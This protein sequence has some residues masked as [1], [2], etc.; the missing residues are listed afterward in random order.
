MAPRVPRASRP[1]E[2]PKRADRQPSARRL[3][4]RAPSLRVHDRHAEG[5]LLGRAPS[6]A[7]GRWP[8][9]AGARRGAS[10]RTGSPRRTR[11]GTRCSRSTVNRYA[12]VA[13]AAAARPGNRPA[14]APRPRARTD[15]MSPARSSPLGLVEAELVEQRIEDA[16]R[17]ERPA[18]RQPRHVG[19]RA[20]RPEDATDL[21]QGPGPVGHELEHERRHRRIEGGVLERQLRRRTATSGRRSAPDRGRRAAP[22]ARWTAPPT[23]SRRHRCR[24][25][26]TAGQRRRAGMARLPVPTPTSRRSCRRRPRRGSS[27]S[28]RATRA[29]RQ[30]RRPPLLVARRHPVVAFPWS[31]ID[32][33]VPCAV[34][35]ASSLAGSAAARPRVGRGRS[36]NRRTIQARRRDDEPDADEQASAA[37]RWRTRCRPSSGPAGRRSGWPT[38]R[39]RR[40]PAPSPLGDLDGDDRH[41]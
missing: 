5:H 26:R 36:A 14:A 19:E 11:S 29:G 6:A 18:V 13:G 34:S 16:V 10:P 22:S 4:V 3:A 40:R 30:D 35:R 23:I 25:T 24:S 2:D 32:A 37:T 20:A 21:A 28:S 38:P 41:A 33:I 7:R 8:G 12:S 31:V 9:T 17:G 27:R 1:A 39:R 15:G